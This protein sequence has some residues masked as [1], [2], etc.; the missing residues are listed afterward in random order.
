MA[1]KG[2]T[3]SI[4]TLLCDSGSRYLDS[5]FDDAWLHDRHI[6]WRPHAASIASLFQ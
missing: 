4:V 2:E 1:A 3:G 5:Y 6:D